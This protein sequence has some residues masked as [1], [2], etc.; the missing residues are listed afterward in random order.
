[1][2]ATRCAIGNIAAEPQ[3]KFGENVYI[4]IEISCEETSKKVD[5]KTH[6]KSVFVCEFELYNVLCV[7]QNIPQ[8]P[9]SAY[10]GNCNVCVFVRHVEDEIFG[11]CRC[12]RMNENMV[13]GFARG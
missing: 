4:R 3:L 9:S 5:T 6:D 12:K 2:P 10:I 13:V 1:M 11:V 8:I 7:L